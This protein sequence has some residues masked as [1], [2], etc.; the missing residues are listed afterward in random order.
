MTFVSYAQNRE[1]VMLWRALS[2]VAQGFY[3][4]VGANH[5]SHDSVT[6][7]FY[8]RG[9]SGI[10][11]EPLQKHYEELLLER[12]RDINLQVAAGAHE[13]E[14]DLYDSLVRGLATASA[15][16]AQARLE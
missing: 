2:S 11:I 4:D 8:E 13:G 14:I 1:D 5:P 15:E 12:P 9:W 6:K 16:V 3:V 7:A 10:N